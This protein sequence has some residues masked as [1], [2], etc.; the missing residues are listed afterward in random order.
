[1]LLYLNSMCQEEDCALAAVILLLTAHLATS[2]TSIFRGYEPGPSL[3]RLGAM[4][5]PYRDTSWCQLPPWSCRYVIQA[6]P[7]SASSV[8]MLPIHSFSLLQMPSHIW[9]AVP[10]LVSST[11]GAFK[12]M[13]GARNLR[14]SIPADLQHTFIRAHVFRDAL[15]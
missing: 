10:P 14:A 2:W 1:M 7:T 6:S 8:P 13:L 3:Q 11:S 15:L 12:G 5:A 9:T 4:Q